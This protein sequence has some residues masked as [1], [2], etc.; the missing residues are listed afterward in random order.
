MDETSNSSIGHWMVQD[1]DGAVEPF[2]S[3]VSFLTP[4][5]G[6]YYITVKNKN[7]NSPGGYSLLLEKTTAIGGWGGYPL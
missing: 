6:T 3:R 7:C 1:D 4:V 5:A 2:S